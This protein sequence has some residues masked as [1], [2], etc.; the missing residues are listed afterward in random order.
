MRV[1][2]GIKQIVKSLHKDC[3]SMTSAAMRVFEEELFQVEQY[4]VKHQ[5]EDNMEVYMNELSSDWQQAIGSHGVWD[6]ETFDKKI[7]VKW[8]FEGKTAQGKPSYS[9][10]SIKWK[11]LEKKGT[12]NSKNLGKKLIYAA[13]S[14][15]LIIAGNAV[16][17]SG[18]IDFK[19]L[20][21]VAGAL[22]TA[23]AATLGNTG[24]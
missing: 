11:K 6:I 21:E 22:L 19:T 18:V 4:V 10:T 24:D 8:V 17:L 14:I 15:P 23:I 9:F 2:K 7:Q 12:Y 13:V 20:A 16:Y 1:K 5:A 3:V